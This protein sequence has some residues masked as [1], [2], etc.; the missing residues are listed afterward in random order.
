MSLDALRYQV[1]YVDIDASGVMHFSR[2]TSLMETAIFKKIELADFN[3]AECDLMVVNL[4]V[5]YHH[6]AQYGDILIFDVD[7]LN[8]GF[9]SLLFEIKIK[10]NQGILLAEGHLNFGCVDL[11]THK[12]VQIPPE[13]N[14]LL[15]PNK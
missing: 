13:I 12:P 6:P 2:Y 7:T 10:N 9:A 5:R 1:E 15:Q 4:K 3:A 14:Q 11:N 8:I